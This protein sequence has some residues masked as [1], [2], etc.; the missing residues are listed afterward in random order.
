MFASVCRDVTAHQLKP[1]VCK[2]HQNSGW[3]GTTQ[4]NISC[5]TVTE[6]VAQLGT[7]KALLMPC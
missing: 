7:T 2:L 1:H 3:Q 4:L 6:E 5:H